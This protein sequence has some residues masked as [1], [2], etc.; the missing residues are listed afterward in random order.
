[1]TESQM[2]ACPYTQMHYSGREI[3]PLNKT[4]YKIQVSESSFKYLPIAC[5]KT[6]HKLQ[7]LVFPE[8]QLFLQCRVIST[9]FVYRKVI[10]GRYCFSSK[11]LVTCAK[12]RVTHKPQGLNCRTEARYMWTEG[13]NEIIL[14]TRR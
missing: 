12:R 9:V 11:M 14:R 1:M 5:L 13:A 2:R 7:F 8:S 6:W 3:N 10:P 4:R